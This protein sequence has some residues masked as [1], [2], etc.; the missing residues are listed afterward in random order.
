MTDP[1]RNALK[2]RDLQLGMSML[3]GIWVVFFV[4]AAIAPHVH[5]APKLAL[6]LIVG[7]LVATITLAVIGVRAII[8][9]WRWNRSFVR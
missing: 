1:D 8:R 5:S 3:S 4:F 6:A 2:N 7:C 9:F